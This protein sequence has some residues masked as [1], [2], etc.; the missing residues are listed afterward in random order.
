MITRLS[1]RRSILLVGAL[2]WTLL[3]VSISAGPGGG[4]GGGGGGSHGGGGAHAGGNS[5][6]SSG[7]YHASPNGR[8][9]TSA[10]GAYSRAGS[11]NPYP[12][13]DASGPYSP[14][15]FVAAEDASRAVAADPNL[16]RLA[17]H[18][19]SFLPSSGVAA[20]TA[21]SRQT[22][23][24]LLP[25]R[26]TN[27]PGVLPLRPRLPYR[28]GV[29]FGGCFFSG[30]TSICGLN[31][32]FYGAFG[33]N[34]C[35][36]PIGFWNC[37]YGYGYGPG[38]GYYDGYGYGPGPGYGY[39]YDNGVNGYPADV[40]GDAQNNADNP[41]LYAPYFG[42]LNENAAQN[43]PE[44]APQVAPATPVQIILKNGRAY[45]VTA[46]WV[47]NGELYYRPVTGGLNH[48]PVDQLDLN[49]TVQANSRNGVAFQLT[50]H[51][52]QP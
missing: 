28:Y 16:S 35:F 27:I 19:W 3:P 36:S 22:A 7:S 40:P 30:F 1:L 14:T 5:S 10:G 45:Q 12:R 34:Y 13:S 26:V 44:E 4:H 21:A 37:T 39:G 33:A 23:R 9:A 32:F 43:P 41:D 31:P 6:H 18:G 8:V 24:P 38:Y 15:N 52:P 29:G 48:V 42:N 47:S 46:Y 51:P 11:E 49:A 20:V 2:S 25:A 17:G 50:D